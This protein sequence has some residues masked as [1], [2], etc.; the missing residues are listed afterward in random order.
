M[1]VVLEEVFALVQDEEMAWR[2][3][4]TIVALRSLAWHMDR[5]H[6]RFEQR[7]SG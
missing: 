6:R 3:V 2:S 1:R 4:A 5:S 7:P